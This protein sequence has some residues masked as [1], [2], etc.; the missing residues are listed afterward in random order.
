LNPQE[1]ATIL[2]HE[3][4][5]QIRAGLHCAPGAHRSLGTLENGGTVR[6]SFGTAT[7]TDDVDR[8][9]EALRRLTAE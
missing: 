7:T 1:V 6:V 8:L 2:D 9:V 3:F 4:E 5:I